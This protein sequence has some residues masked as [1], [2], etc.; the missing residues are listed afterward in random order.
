M[1]NAFFGQF[2]LKL[3]PVEP[4]QLGSLL[5]PPGAYVVFARADVEVLVPEN[6]PDGVTPRVRCQLACFGV[7]AV[8]E[9]KCLRIPNPAGPVFEFGRATI[10][11]NIAVSFPLLL[12][13][14]EPNPHPERPE[15]CELLCSCDLGDACLASNI[16]MSA[17][18]V[19]R[20]NPT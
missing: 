6:V 15:L 19:D 4:V 17:I 7:T 11:L 10:M 9:Q 2:E 18:E 20:I 8:S 13:D 1:S 14:G 3:I 16:V 5:L 12:I